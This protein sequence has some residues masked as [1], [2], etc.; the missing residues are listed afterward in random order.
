MKLSADFS[1]RNLR[2]LLGKEFQ[3]QG[4][5][6]SGGTNLKGL[7]LDVFPGGGWISIGGKRLRVSSKSDILFVG[8]RL[9]LVAKSDKKGI[10]LRIVER[11]LIGKEDFP[12]KLESVGMSVRELS[13][14]VM[15]SDTKDVPSETSLFKVLKSYYPFLEWASEL[16]YFRWEFDGGNAEGVYDPQ[17]ESKKFLFRI[18]TE[19]T[20]RTVVLFLWKETSGEDMQI[21]AS[22]DNL[23]MYL[24]ACQNKEKFKRSL[25]ESSVSFQGYNLAY[26]PSLI[27]KEWNA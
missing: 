14:K 15:G 23:K 2:L 10:E 6:L 25:I 16:P 18:Q 22:F 5:D 3:F 12:H 13:E 26:K 19:N 8:E 9:T 24:H 20:G 21:N 27:Q 7:V 1:A 17:R 11:E 4:L